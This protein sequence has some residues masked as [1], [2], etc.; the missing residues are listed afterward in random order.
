MFWLVFVW[1][2]CT[3]IFVHEFNNNFVFAGSHWLLLLAFGR[4]SFLLISDTTER[5]DGETTCLVKREKQINEL[6]EFKSC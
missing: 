6:T 1:N 2:T 3:L 4:G 5:K